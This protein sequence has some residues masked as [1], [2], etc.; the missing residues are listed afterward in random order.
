VEYD[1]SREECAQTRVRAS[2]NPLRYAESER[3][4]MPFAS[5]PGLNFSNPG[6]RGVLFCPR[7]RF[8]GREERDVT[9]LKVARKRMGLT[10]TELARRTAHHATRRGAASARPPRRLRS[11]PVPARGA[12]LRRRAAR[13]RGQTETRKGGE[14]GERRSEV[15][16]TPETRNPTPLAKAV[17]IAQTRLR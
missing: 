4:A 17:G 11:A 14:A 8:I 10:Q 13:L 7:Y 5:E 9:R 3:W 15:T 6:T 16:E 2:H 12:A 1:K